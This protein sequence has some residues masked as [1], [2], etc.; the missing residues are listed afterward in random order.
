MNTRQVLEE[1]AA[2]YGVYLAFQAVQLLLPPLGFPGAIIDAFAGSVA[3]FFTPLKKCLRPIGTALTYGATS[4]FVVLLI[5][6]NVVTAGGTESFL[7]HLLT[8]A[9]MY[10]L[11]YR[12]CRYPKKVPCQ[13]TE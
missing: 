4:G 11:F 6:D 1:L 3:F 9:A 10:S 7:V 2:L 12:Q 8:L 13:V 5:S